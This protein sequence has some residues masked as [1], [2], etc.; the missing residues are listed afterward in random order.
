MLRLQTL[1]RKRQNIRP[2]KLG[3]FGFKPKPKVLQ[4][5]RKHSAENA[6]TF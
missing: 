3:V 2:K 6:T 1:E 4:A 5:G